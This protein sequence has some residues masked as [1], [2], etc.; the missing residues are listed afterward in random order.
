ML[1]D[2]DRIRDPIKLESALA[3]RILNLLN[4]RAEGYMNVEPLS[5]FFGA[6]LGDGYLYE[7][8]GRFRTGI[9]C[10]DLDIVERCYQD[11][12]NY[13][14]DL[15]LG[16]RRSYVIPS[17]KLMF[18]VKW[19]DRQFYDLVYNAIGNKYCLP[20]YIWTASKKAKLDLLAGLMD[21]DGSINTNVR[22]GFQLSFSGN[23]P[24][25]TEFPRL[26]HGL[27]ISISSK[28]TQKRDIISY[29][30]SVVNAIHSGFQ[31]YCNRKHQ[32]YLRAFAHYLPK[33]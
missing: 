8:K 32:T 29:N 20:E 33:N 13:F 28:H 5:Y 27:G 7:D 30:F 17:G 31:F 2:A 19:S 10:S 16:R 11:I 25:V 22:K 4:N 21:T 24:F 3:F 15:R 9:D 26:L 12:T 23:R 6:I 14:S 1:R 18:Q